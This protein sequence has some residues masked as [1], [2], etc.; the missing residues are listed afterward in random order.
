MLRLKCFSLTIDG[1]IFEYDDLI[2]PLLRRM[3]NLEEL[4]LYLSVARHNS[5]YID[6]N[7]LYDQ[8]LIYMTQL[9]KFTFYIKSQIYND[10]VT[11]K[12]PSNEDIKH[13]FIRRIYQEVASYTRAYSNLCDGK[14]HIYS[15]PYDFEYFFDLDNSFPGGMFHKVRQLKMSDVIPFEYN[16]FKLIS[17]DFPFLEI[18]YVFNRYPQKDK[19][20]SSILITF[21]YLKFLDLDSAHVDYVELFLLKQNMYLPRLINLFINYESLV[22]IT[23]NFTDDATLFNFNTL[24]SIQCKECTLPDNFC[25]YAPFL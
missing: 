25:Q 6:S 18:L 22:T 8:F 1:L 5:S 13:S 12:L 24:K 23:N 4:K 2:V 15:L 21:P 16:L 7:Q 19:Q 3:I 14:C 10:H 11:L 9:K 20:N 17:Q